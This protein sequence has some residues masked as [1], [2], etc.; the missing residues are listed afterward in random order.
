M[1]VGRGREEKAGHELT[2]KQKG[3]ATWGKEMKEGEQIQI[4]MGGELPA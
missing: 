4:I 1:G 3:M 2:W